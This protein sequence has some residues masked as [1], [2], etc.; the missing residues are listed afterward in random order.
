M[1]VFPGRHSVFW[2][3]VAGIGKPMICKYWDGTTH[4]DNGGN[5]K[6][7]YQDSV[8]E[9]QEAINETI[10]PENYQ[11]MSSIAIENAKKFCYKD[12]AL[13]CIK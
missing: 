8:A 7:L 5:V 2:E 12:I 4:I 13:R 1:V 9:I 10:N 3:E 11:K 6:F